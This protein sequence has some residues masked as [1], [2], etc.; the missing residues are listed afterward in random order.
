MKQQKF[1]QSLDFILPVH[2]GEN[3]SICFSF[4]ESCVTMPMTY[5]IHASHDTCSV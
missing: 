3:K 2:L 4:K 5:M 1:F